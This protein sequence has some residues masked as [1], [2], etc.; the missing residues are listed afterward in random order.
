MNQRGRAGGKLHRA[1]RR[2]QPENETRFLPCFLAFDVI[3]QLH[4]EPII[5]PLQP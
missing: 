2:R 4:K 1:V 3:C 5:H